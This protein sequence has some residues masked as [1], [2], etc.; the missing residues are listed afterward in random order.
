LRQSEEKFKSIFE[1][2]KDAIML[3]NKSG[4]FDCNQQALELFGISSKEELIK[5]HPADISPPVQPDG[6][7]SFESSE[8]K[9]R[10]AFQQGSIRFEWIHRR[11]NGEV[12]PAEVHMSEFNIAEERVLQATV[13]D[14]T[15]RKRAEKE[16]T[17]ARKNAVESDNLKS[18]FLHNISHEI[19]TPMNQIL[20]FASF[21]KDP[22]LTEQKRVDYIKVINRQ[23][24]SL[25]HI[26]DSIIEISQISTG[27]VNLKLSVFNLGEMMDELFTSFKPKAEYRNLQLNFIKKLSDADTVVRGDKMKL[28]QVFNNLIENAIKYTDTGNVDIEYSRNGD[29]LIIVVRDTGIGLQEQ[30]KQLIFEHFR[31]VEV[32]MAKKYGGLGL[33]L[34]ISSAYIR[35]MGGSIRVESLP[36]K[37]ST[38]TV[39]LPD[40][41]AI[42]ASTYNE[43]GWHIHEKS[44]PD[45]RG[46]TLLI[47]EDEESNAEFLSIA[48]RATQIQLLFATNGLEAVEQCRFHP[49]ISMVLMDIKMPRMDGL[50]ATKIIKSLRF[51][52][53]IIATTAFA[54]TDERDFILQSGCDDYLPKPIK[55]E[56]LIAKIQ[57]HMAGKSTISN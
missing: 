4:F 27:Q 42:H 29:R 22:D 50:E 54:R 49:E 2:S 26:I 45:W 3:I 51:D 53:P 24:Y 48:L 55:P 19:R 21:L 39:E 31:Q 25:L 7:I 30:E 20:G 13:I 33:G 1:S 35:M 57:K 43:K 23:S 56:D 28:N 5:L 52:L 47:A 41:P 11:S 44:Q 14:L 36:G 10:T 17:D 32:S 8:E 12:F 9:I 18:A 46:M 6:R 38:F 37:G 34:A 15:D 40:M 16:L